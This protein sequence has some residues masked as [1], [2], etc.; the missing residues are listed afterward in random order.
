[1]KTIIEGH[2]KN[3]ICITTNGEQD[4]IKCEDSIVKLWLSSGTILG[5]KYGNMLYPNSW[6]IRILHG[7]MNKNYVYR[8]CLYRTEEDKPFDLECD[9]D[10]FE[11]EEEVL[12][13]RVIPRT[14]YMGR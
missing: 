9:S 12:N 10:I 4:I 6:L 13:Y 8:Q 3:S 11:T 2:N 14:Y 1:M 7:P 5:M